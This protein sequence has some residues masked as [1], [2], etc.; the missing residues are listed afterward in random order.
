MT[1]KW[2][3]KW[4]GHTSPYIACVMFRIEL[5]ATNLEDLVKSWPDFA[6]LKCSRCQIERVRY[7]GDGKFTYGDPSLSAKAGIQQ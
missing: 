3:C 7:L 4:F 2:L 6:V 1:A 5:K